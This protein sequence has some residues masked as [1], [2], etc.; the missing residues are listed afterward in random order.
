MKQHIII[1]RHNYIQDKYEIQVQID[2][3]TNKLFKKKKKKN[4]IK[5]LI[6]IQ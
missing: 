2:F 6:S 3:N 5:K 1:S 4:F